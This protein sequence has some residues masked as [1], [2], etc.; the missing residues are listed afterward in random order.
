MAEEKP[1]GDHGARINRLESEQSQIWDAIDKIR[2]RLPNWAVF[3]I[4][5]LSGGLGW[6]LQWGFTMAKI[7]A[8]GS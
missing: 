5:A 1:C 7:A 3:L 2:N 6:A 8:A 4:A